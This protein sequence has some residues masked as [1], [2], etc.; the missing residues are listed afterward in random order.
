MAQVEPVLIILSLTTRWIAM[1]L[2]DLVKRR[3]QL[4][5]MTNPRCSMIL[6]TISTTKVT[7]TVMDLVTKVNH[8]FLVQ[9]LKT[10]NKLKTLSLKVLPRVKVKLVHLA[11]SR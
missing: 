6:I 1:T 9:I 11:Q 10:L 4:K 3:N 8:H 7:A 5:P 2:Q